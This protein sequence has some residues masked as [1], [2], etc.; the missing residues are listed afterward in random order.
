MTLVST[1]ILVGTIAVIIF[2]LVLLTAKQYKKVGPNEVL[3]S[4]FSRKRSSS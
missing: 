3:I 2:L 1:L 4:L